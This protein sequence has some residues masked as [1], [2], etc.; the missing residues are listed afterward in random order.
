M[1]D[2]K[3]NRRQMLATGVAG[4]AMTLI[5]NMSLAA[6]TWDMPSAYGAGNFISKAYAA[7]GT[8]VST[9]TNGDFA[10]T[11]HPGGSL[12]SVRVIFRAFR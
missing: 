12:S 4:S 1:T 6:T 8:D 2:I 9:R 3:L 5:P 11:L 7:F 10:I